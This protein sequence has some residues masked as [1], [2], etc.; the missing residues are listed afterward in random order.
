VKITAYITAGGSSSR[1]TEDKSLYLYRGKPLVQHVYDVLKSIF[2]SVFVIA[3]KAGK[4]CF[5]KTE[6]IPDLVKGFGPKGGLYTALA[7][8]PSERIFFCGC[9]MPNISEGLVRHMVAL[10]NDYDVVVPVV[11]K[12]YDP[13]HAVYSKQCL[14]FVKDSIASGRKKI[15]AFYP[16]V[17]VRE[18]PAEEMQRFG[19]WEEMLCNVNYKHDI[20]ES[21]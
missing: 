7:H 15:I 20:T 5:L 11:P 14:P 10:S 6:V 1:F 4:Y 19:N 9:D 3:D 21:G 2:P 17:R 13:L 18:V 8:A 16:Q 12:G